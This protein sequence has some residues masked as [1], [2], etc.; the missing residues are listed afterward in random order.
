MMM[1]MALICIF[2]S[3]FFEN[4]NPNGR[5]QCQ[6]AQE[7][8]GRSFGVTG[9]QEKG[10]GMESRRCREG[11]VLVF[12]GPDEMLARPQAGVRNGKAFCVMSLFAL[13]E[14]SKY[15]P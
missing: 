2:T 6:G 9:T 1:I 12:E 11:C 3:H 8:Q 10:L 14:G 15:N 4:R 7:F 13:N 5:T